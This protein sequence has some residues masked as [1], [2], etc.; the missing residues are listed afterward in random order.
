M[1]IKK[2]KPTSPGIRFKTGF[3]FEEITSE[4]PF[5]GL[6]TGVVKGGGRNNYG[7]ITVRHRGGGHKRRFRDV[8]LRRDKYDVPSK[9][10]S[11][12]YDPDRKSVV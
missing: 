12:E 1:A 11:V 10:V 2:Y 9:V 4:K 5:K 6:T 8:D 3:A 7:R